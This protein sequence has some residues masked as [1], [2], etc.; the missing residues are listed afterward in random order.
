MGPITQKIR[1][2]LLGIQKEEIEDP[3]GWIY[4]IN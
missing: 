2:I 1:E 4:P 3:F